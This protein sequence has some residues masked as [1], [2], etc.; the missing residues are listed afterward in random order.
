MSSLSDS[1]INASVHFV[2][3]ILFF[4]ITKFRYF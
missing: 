1:I 2:K 4:T 3:R